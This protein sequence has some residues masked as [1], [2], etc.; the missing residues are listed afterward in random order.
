MVKTMK[1][2]LDDNNFDNNFVFRNQNC[3]AEMKEEI[4]KRFNEKIDYLLSK[5]YTQEKLQAT[6][7]RIVN[8]ENTNIFYDHTGTKRLEWTIPEII[9]KEGKKIIQFSINSEKVD[10]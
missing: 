7:C 6:G 2:E 1:M 4:T 5:I 9:E 10:I 3:L 8:K